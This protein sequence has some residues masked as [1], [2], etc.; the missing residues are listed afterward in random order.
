M[1]L[2]AQNLFS[3]NQSITTGTIYSTNTVKFGKNDVSFVPV[4]V[5]AVRD[6][7]NLTSLTL[8]IQTDDNEAFSNPVDLLVSSLNKAE[9]KAGAKFPVSYLPRGNKGYMR[10]AFVVTGSTETTGAITAGVVAG[11]GL[12][13][14]EI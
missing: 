1:L 13:I 7:S 12:E 10:L 4:I 5:Q 8:K 2:D 6:F 9:L 3:D 14:Q 11:D